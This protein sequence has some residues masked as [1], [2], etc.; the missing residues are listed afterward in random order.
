MAVSRRSGE[1]A[2]G[3]ASSSRLS[4]IPRANLSAMNSRSEAPPAGIVLITGAARR[5]GAAMALEL[6]RRG[7][8]VVLHYRSSAEAAEA[9]ADQLR[10]LGRRAWTIP[11]DLADPAACEELVP[12]ALELTG[13]LN[14]LINNASIFPR[15]TLLEFEPTDLIESVQI[16]GIAPSL[17]ARAFARCPEARQILN[18]TDSKTTGPDDEHFAYH[19]SKRMLA[20]LTS[21]MAR[22]LAP[23]IAVNAIAPGAM[24]PAEGDDAT[25]FASLAES[26]PLQKTGSPE[27]VARAAA[28]LL[29]SEFITGQV[30]YIDGG[31]H[32]EGCLYG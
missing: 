27:D 6:G 12:R 4:A 1:Q 9:L 17:L 2:P 18:I 8:D 19:L 28:F 16:H 15:S 25:Y 32:L 23:A 5:L 7:W 26:I 30:L 24:L 14:A 11:S 10:A 13:S 20:S 22:Q 31:R 29:E 3:A 21:L